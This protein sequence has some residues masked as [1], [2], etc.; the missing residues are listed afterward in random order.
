L[1]IFRFL[2]SCASCRR[3]MD[4]NVGKL[5]KARGVCPQRALSLSDK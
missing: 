2:T 4:Y 1:L 5:I 3:S